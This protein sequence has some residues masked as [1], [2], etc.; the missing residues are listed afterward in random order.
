MGNRRGT[1]FPS[2]SR[3]G[4]GWAFGGWSTTVA[5]MCAREL[6][7]DGVPRYKA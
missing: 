1:G 7:S 3:I 4:Q 6:M 2:D 5:P